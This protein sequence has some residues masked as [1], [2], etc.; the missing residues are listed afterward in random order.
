MNRIR[1]ILLPPQILLNIKAA[2]REEA[3]KQVAD[4]LQGDNR[5]IDWPRFSSSLS[6]C[7]R[8]S[9]INIGLGLTIP[10][11]RTKSVT[12]MVM[13][14]GRLAEPIRRGPASIRFVLAIGIPETMDADY[15]RLVG[16]LMRAFKDNQLRKTLETAKTPG[17][18]LTAFEKGETRVS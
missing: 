12:S 3:I 2:T 8:S 14:F 15:L 17:E 7:A 13:A 16:V 10:H 18:V 9:R 4:S 6:E 5:I 11:N 1:E